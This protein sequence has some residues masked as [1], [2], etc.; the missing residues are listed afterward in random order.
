MVANRKTEFESIVTVEDFGH[1]LEIL[2]P[3]PEYDIIF[4]T[5][6]NISSGSSQPTPEELSLSETA[7]IVCHKPLAPMMETV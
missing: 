3:S 1:K 2:A 4:T 6:C 5:R 7:V